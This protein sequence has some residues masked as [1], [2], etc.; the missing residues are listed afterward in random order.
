MS[1]MTQTS[2]PFHIAEV[3]VLGCGDGPGWWEAVASYNSP[4]AARSSHSMNVET[5]G[6]RDRVWMFG[7]VTTSGFRNDLWFFDLKQLKWEQP[8]II[9]DVRPTERESH[10]S[11][12]HKTSAGTVR[13][14][15]FGGETATSAGAVYL[16]D[17]WVVD[18]SDVQSNGLSWTE[19]NV[20]QSTSFPEARATHV[21]E[22]YNNKMI[23]YG[24]Y[25]ATS[26]FNDF[27]TLDLEVTK[28]L[29]IHVMSR[30]LHY[31]EL[32]QPP[33]SAQLK[34]S[35]CS[36]YIHCAAAELAA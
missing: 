6:A 9:G 29:I 30:P 11:V 4:P 5:G 33:S 10:C 24:G 1:E 13:L 16:G 20:S 28:T 19:F 8:T 36:I 32:A 7:G 15:V 21:C 18:F 14:F 23:A 34:T 17:T 35:V 31:S 22:L 12:L 27:W 25:S 26:Y 2:I 3:T